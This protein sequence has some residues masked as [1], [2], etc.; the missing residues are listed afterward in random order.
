MVRVQ[1]AVIAAVVVGLIA[2]PA[3]AFEP[4]EG[5]IAMVADE[6]AEVEVTPVHKSSD[7]VGMPVKSPEG[8][9]IG[10]INE[11]VLDLKS[12]QIKYVAVSFG[13]FLGFGNKLFAFPWKAIKITHKSNERHFE[14]AVSPE[15]L[16]T[17][18]GFDP[19]KWP[20]ELDARWQ[21]MIDQYNKSH[22]QP[23][24]RAAKSQ[25]TERE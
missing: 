12:G 2:G 17:A 14:L 22:P 11:V 9:E 4:F 1:Y 25:A 8:K 23:P 21:R 19:D 20:E 6:G 5:A 15:Q 18:E 10:T 7:I 3:A 13:G 24:A 16:K